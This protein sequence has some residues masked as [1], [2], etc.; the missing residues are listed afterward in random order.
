MTKRAKMKRNKVETRVDNQ[1]DP[2]QSLHPDIYVQYQDMEIVT[3]DM[4]E[5]VKQM[6]LESGHT[7]EE[8]KTLKVY[9]KPEESAA[10]YVIN[11]EDSGKVEIN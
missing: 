6:Y 2:E 1:V 11:E 8:I 9:I 5:K 4:V 3:K 7:L 10:Y